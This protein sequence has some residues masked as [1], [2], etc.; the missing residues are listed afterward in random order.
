[1]VAGSEGCA[2]A[3]P[4]MLCRRRGPGG[5]DPTMSCSGDCK[6]SVEWSGCWRWSGR[7]GGAG[8]TAATVLVGLSVSA[9][10]LVASAP[11]RRRCCW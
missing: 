2:G 4:V 11:L 9:L 8:S 7:G 10:L 6:W 1:M 3:S 5:V